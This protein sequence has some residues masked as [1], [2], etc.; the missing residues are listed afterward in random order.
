MGQKTRA[1]FW[2]A[3]LIDCSATSGI[4]VPH[5]RVEWTN[6]GGWWLRNFSFDQQGPLAFLPLSSLLALYFLLS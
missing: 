3:A 4:N 5:Y 1:Y 6:P 2:F